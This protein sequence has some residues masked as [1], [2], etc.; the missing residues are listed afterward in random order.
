M[1]KAEIDAIINKIA[2]LEQKGILNNAPSLGQTEFMRELEILS[3][4]NQRLWRSMTKLEE[5]LKNVTGQL[6]EVEATED[7]SVPGALGKSSKDQKHRKKTPNAKK[8]SVG[9]A[10]NSHS[11]FVPFNKLCDVLIVKNKSSYPRY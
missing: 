4:E 6:K 10:K 9:H 5:T 3:D 7:P 1:S 11:Y 2:K 8:F